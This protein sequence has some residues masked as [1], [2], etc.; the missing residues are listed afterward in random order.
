MMLSYQNGRSA[1]FSSDSEG[2]LK[3]PMVQYFIRH[4]LKFE[5]TLHDEKYEI[6]IRHFYTL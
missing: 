2:G 5:L 1:F 4:V 6:T 3:Q